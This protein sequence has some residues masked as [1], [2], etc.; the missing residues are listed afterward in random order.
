MKLFKLSI[1]IFIIFFFIIQTNSFAYLDPVTGSNLLQ[2]LLALLAAV[3]SFFGFYWRRFTSYFKKSDKSDKSKKK[4]EAIKK[5][6]I[7]WGG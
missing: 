7:G 2:I 5:L 6:K 1:N 3:G 4:T